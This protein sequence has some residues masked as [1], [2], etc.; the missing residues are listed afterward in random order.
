MCSGALAAPKVLN[1]P[2]LGRFKGDWL[3]T[4]RW[5][6]GDVS[7]DDLRVGIIGTGSSAAQAVPELA[8][9]A[10]KLY[11]F[12]RHPHYAIPAQNGPVDPALQ[13]AVARN[14]GS[15]RDKSLRGS[16]ADN[17]SGGAVPL[18]PFEGPTLSATEYTCVQRL[19]RLEAQ[20]E[21]GGHGM[22]YMFSDQRTN[23]EANTIVADFIRRKIREQVADHTVAETLSPWYP[24]GT[25]RL[26]LEVGYYE[27]FNQD[28]VTLVDV[29]RDPIIEI[30]ETGVRTA[31]TTYEVDLLIFATG[32]R[33]FTGP[34]Q[35]AGIRN[36]DGVT[37]TD[38]WADGPLT[39]FGL[40]TPGF[41][42]LFHPTNAGS[43]SVL[44]NA[45]LQHEF[46]GDWISECI[47][48]MDKDGYSTIEA[49]FSA[50]KEWMNLVDSYAKR[51][52][53]F[54]RA[55]DQYMVQVNPDGSRWFLPFSGRMGEYLPLITKATENNYDGF[56]MR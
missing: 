18:H 17:P 24:V 36:E 25:R 30:T 13:D 1:F 40:M 23:L 41:P 3:R 12:Q 21:F 56:E 16:R 44:G 43:P 8:R 22:S 9:T 45:M 10:K 5:P 4:S 49:S 29:L 32:F 53:P 47:S 6:E 11:V 15:H 46:F 39:L 28:N 34:L 42:N 33:A 26:I 2:G 52:V 14:L 38:A 31:Q 7:L 48:S 19:E 51:L 50:A 37:P 35:D 20:W 27:A 54:R 55:E